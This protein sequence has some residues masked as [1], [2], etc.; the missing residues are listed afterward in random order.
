M[1]DGG[2]A[3]PPDASSS[4]EPPADA[5]MSAEPP[6]DAGTSAEPSIKERTHS[7]EQRPGFN[8]QEII[9]SPNNIKG[10]HGKEER[11]GYHRVTRLRR[12]DPFRPA[13]PEQPNASRQHNRA[14]RTRLCRPGLHA[15]RQQ[16]W[17]GHVGDAR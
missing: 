2:I 12:P 9:G 15:E 4:A 13:S 7:P 8:Q 10:Q 17:Q 14:L 16:C 11:S 6:D 3:P 5:S 1:A